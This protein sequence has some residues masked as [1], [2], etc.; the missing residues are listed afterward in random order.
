MEIIK[1][2]IVKEFVRKYRYKVLFVLSTPFY[3]VWLVNSPRIPQSIDVKQTVERHYS[4]REN[5]KESNWLSAIDSYE[6]FISADSSYKSS[7]EHFISVLDNP[8]LLDFFYNLSHKY[9][10]TYANMGNEKPIRREN[11][12]D[13]IVNEIKRIRTYITRSSVLTRSM[14]DYDFGESLDEN[15]FRHDKLKVIIQSKISLIEED[16]EA[17]KGKLDYIRNNPCSYY[18]YDYDKSF[19]FRYENRRNFEKIGYN[20]CENTE[21][22]Y[23]VNADDFDEFL[24]AWDGMIVFFWFSFETIFSDDK[25]VFNFYDKPII[26]HAY[27]YGAV[28]STQKKAVHGMVDLMLNFGYRLGG[29]TICYSLLIILFLYE[30]F[31]SLRPSL[32]EYYKHILLVSDKSTRNEYKKK[33]ALLNRLLAENLISLKKLKIKLND[34]VTYDPEEAQDEDANI[35]RNSINQLELERQSFKQKIK[36]LRNEMIEKINQAKKDNDRANKEDTLKR[37]FE[38]GILTKD[39]YYNKLNDMNKN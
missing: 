39:E 5:Q 7:L 30:G 15:K 3:I 32:L 22:N 29:F 25:W 27:Q 17:Y 20:F 35:I 21:L 31:K 24:N 13:F 33:L 18:P 9:P 1:D 23:Q 28:T 2:K 36:E 14:L 16:I 10:E 6:K 38:E 26:R 34:T 11:L 8:G 12:N 37:A 19:Y 4:A